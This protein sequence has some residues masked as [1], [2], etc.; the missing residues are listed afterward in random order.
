MKNYL[1]KLRNDLKI[2]AQEKTVRAL[3]GLAG[4]IRQKQAQNLKNAITV[5]IPT[6]RQPHQLRV[7]LDENEQ[8]V[9][10]HFEA[11]KP[12]PFKDEIRITLDPPKMANYGHQKRAARV[13]DSVKA[14]ING[15]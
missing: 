5:E 15:I 10:V 6:K 2:V 13:V 3:E 4:K 7:Q 11:E 9:D 14:F 12:T 1:T 8:V